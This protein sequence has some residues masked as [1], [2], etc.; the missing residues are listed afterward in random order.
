MVFHGQFQ[1]SLAAESLGMPEHRGLDWPN[2]AEPFFLVAEHVFNALFIAEQICRIRKLRLKYLSETHNIIDAVIV[3]STSIDLY[4]LQPLGGGG[5]NVM[6]ARLIRITRLARIC[7]VFRIL[8]FAKHMSAFRI[9]FTTLS[10]CTLPILWSMMLLGVILV[11]TGILVTQLTQ[12][13]IHDDL[14][15][16]DMREQVFLSYGSSYKATWTLFESAFS[17]A[18]PAHAR[19]LMQNV[20]HWFVIFWVLFIIVIRFAVLRVIGSLFL[21]ETLRAS[22]NDHDILLMAK[23]KEKDKYQNQFRHFFLAADTSGDG[24]ITRDELAVMM[25][26]ER[27]EAWL[28][29]M[30]VEAHEVEG[31]IRLLD[32]NEDGSVSMEE[33]VAGAMRLKGTARSIDTIAMMHEQTKLAKRIDEIAAN[34]EH[35]HEHI[36]RH[37]S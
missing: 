19:V 23:M 31:L 22:K 35:V 21:N 24:Y 36:F 3:V 14:Q 5:Q 12:D 9:V 2:G 1:G 10:N 17:G 20:S 34:I 33:F 4:V 6:V 13:F 27:V 18:W 32:D 11:G 26:N 8:R 25:Q 15:D 28:E 7:R 30:E 37:Q 16:L 29:L